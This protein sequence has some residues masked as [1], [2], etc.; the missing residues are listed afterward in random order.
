MAGCWIT[1]VKN[2]IQ[3]DSN[4]EELAEK[5]W[6]SWVLEGGRVRDRDGMPVGSDAGS[7]MERYG[8]M[9]PRPR[10]FLD[11]WA[12]FS[13]PNQ[14][15]ERWG[16]MF[17][18]LWAESLTFKVTIVYLGRLLPPSSTQITSFSCHRN[19]S[20]WSHLLFPVYC[21]VLSTPPKPQG[22]LHGVLILLSASL[23]S[24]DHNHLP[25][26]WSLVVFWCRS[27]ESPGLLTKHSFPIEVLII[28]LRETN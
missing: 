1:P 21:T 13:V 19:A 16:W 11:S 6:R 4:G 24:V 3:T 2:S 20:R 8:M 22:H 12:H 5:G 15:E 26:P 17:Q 14:Q 18:S 27:A 23:L 7:G 28:E 9:G 10:T 25:D